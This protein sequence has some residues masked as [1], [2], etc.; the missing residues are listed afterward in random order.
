MSTGD[1]VKL[2]KQLN[3]GFKHFVYWN[4]YKTIPAKVINNEA[5]I[6]KLLRASFQGVKALFV[7]AYDSPDNGNIVIQNNREYFLPRV[8][9]RYYNV[10][11]HGRNFYD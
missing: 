11:I 5:N 4:K 3:D 7:I 8:V 9:I 2:A 1:N 10:L 6:Y